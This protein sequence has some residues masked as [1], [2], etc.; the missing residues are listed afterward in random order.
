MTFTSEGSWSGTVATRSVAGGQHG[1][2]ETEQVRMREER[3]MPYLRL[4]DEV[5]RVGFLSRHT[6]R[7]LDRRASGSI[8]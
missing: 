4:K 7:H 8:Q 6:C 5:A 2:N 1:G 3:V